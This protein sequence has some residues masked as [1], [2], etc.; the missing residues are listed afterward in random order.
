[1]KIVHIVPGSGGTFY[2]QN[3][4]RDGSLVHALRELGHDVIVAPMYLPLGVAQEVLSDRV[5]VFFG[6]VNVYLKQF[7]PGFRKAPA[8]LGRLLDSPP[9]LAW[10]A[11]REGTT[12]ARGLESMTMSMLK[13]EEGKQAEELETLVEWLAGEKGLDVIHLSN[14]LLL[15]LAP[16]LKDRIGV[17]IVCSLQDEDQWVEGMAARFRE[18]IWSAM[19]DRAACVD[20][21]TAVSRFFADKMR[22]RL[23]IPSGSLRVVPIGLDLTGYERAALDF[24]EPAIGYLSRLTASLGLGVLVDAFI[25]LRRQDRF[26]NLRLRCTG[27]ITPGDRRFVRGLERRLLR[28]G[29]REG[30]E[31]LQEFDREHRLRF[32]KSLTVLS[33][34][35]PGGEAF[36]TYQIE[37]LASGVPVVQPNVGAFPEL[38]RTTGGGVIYEPNDS[39][40]LAAAL[41]GLLGD[42]IRARELGDRGRKVVWRDFTIES[43]AAR[44]AQVYRGLK[45]SAS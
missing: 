19:A 43:M 26:R 11:R 38:V 12:Q 3:C 24:S 16:R 31:F 37:A 9:L 39:A 30:V 36:G 33:V 15:G 42:P 5:P 14:A 28:A 22:A 40:H 8:W 44:M 10:A 17:P 6:A 13:G 2:C 20:A 34:P 27:G 18:E 35:V 45:T 1:M 4:M 32:L 29:V 7:V 25:K 41:G 21:F 23:A